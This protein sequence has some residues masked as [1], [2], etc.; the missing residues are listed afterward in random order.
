MTARRAFAP[1]PA[2]AL[3]LVLAAA[4]LSA[5]RAAPERYEIDP[6]HTTIAFLVSHIGYQKVLGQ[7]LEFSGG[8]VF[9]EAE[10][11]LADLEV[12]IQVDSIETH[13][14]D[15]DDHLES[16]DFLAEDDHPEI[17][18]VMTG[19]EPSGERDGRVLGDLT[20]RG[21][22]RPVALDVTWNK[23]GPYPFGDNYVTG[24]SARTSF[25]RSDFG[26]T[27]GVADGLVGDEV[28]VIIE[29]EA[30]RQ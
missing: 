14:A 9:D 24:I 28:V 19:A 2:L 30:I 20:V 12:T 29:L 15:R 6:D 17:R 18:F 16:N 25:K 5:A 26:M 23:S 22:T 3:A 21:V 13:H 27:Y 8:F 11:R 4:P 7:F 1:A 10:R